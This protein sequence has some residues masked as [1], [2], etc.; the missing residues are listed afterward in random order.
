[1]GKNIVIFS[2]GTGQAGGVRP[3]Q[4]LSNIYK[5]YR[6]CRT[7]PDSPINP[8]EQV[9]FYDAG[10]G[11]DADAGSIPLRAAQLFSKLLSS[12]TGRGISTNITDCYEAILKHYQPGDRIFLFG[13][14]RGAYTARCVGGVLSLC[15]VPTTAADGTPLPRYGSALRA[16]AAEAVSQVYE[17]GAGRNRDKFAPERQEKARRFRIKYRSEIEGGANVV[18]YFIGVFDTVASLGSKGL[19]RV[20]DFFLIAMSVI[21]PCG[22]AAA[23]VKVAFDVNFWTV[24]WSLCGLLAAWSILHGIVSSIKIIRNFPT[25]GKSR[26]HWTR[27]QSGFYDLDLNRQVRAARHALAIDET[28]ADFARVPWANQG[29]LEQRP[30][31]EPEW[32]QQI[33]FAGNHSDIGGSYAEDESRLSDMALRWMV[34]EVAKMPHPLI[35]R[36]TVLQLFPDASGMQHSEVESA[37]ALW[38]RWFPSGWKRS[39]TEKPRVEARGATWHPSVLE[40]FGAKAVQ[41][42]GTTAPYRPRTLVKDER[43]APLYGTTPAS[44]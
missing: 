41:Q 33:W 22:L 11:T 18:P 16:V 12:A 36:E 5:L 32:L 25:P 38:P 40:R 4:H 34:D 31:G 3:D 19:R 28:R 2:D 42:Y 1:M 15:G 23:V 6:A 43:V 27:W 14:S 35:V 24:F 39:W 9:A 29:A 26:W 30:A 7:G 37:R 8:V 20:L 13:F 17:H 44:S 21:I 10:L